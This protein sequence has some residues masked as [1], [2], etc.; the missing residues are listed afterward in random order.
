MT[1]EPLCVPADNPG[2]M[3]GDGNNTWLLDGPAPT[4]ID[5]GTGNPSHV[6][7]VMRVLAGRSL[8]RVLVT[9]GHPDH[10]SGVVALKSRWPSLEACKFP[11][12]GEFGWRALRDGDRVRAGDGELTV[13]HTPG[14][15]EDHV[16]FWDAERRW[17]Y[18]GDMLLGHTTVMIP[19]GRGGSL[20]LYLES[21]ERLRALGPVR[22][23]PG[24]G[25]TL[26][27][28]DDLLAK[29]IEHRL[30]RERQIVAALDE[31]VADVETIVNR[32]YP[33]LTDGLRRAAMM[34]SVVTI[35]K[36]GRSCHESS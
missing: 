31:G 29:Q 5:A 27:H 18:G 19:S 28:P 1:P 23:Y 21:L 7:S 33:G 25:D 6:A 11:L 4:L 16:C 2:L 36:S 10:A 35:K 26:D 13:V 9:H 30:L 12:H 22:V 15:A 24:H 34:T 20:R 3:T 14:H 17:L 32:I 8:A